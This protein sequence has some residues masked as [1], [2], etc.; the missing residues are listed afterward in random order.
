MNE[1]KFMQLIRD[2]NAMQNDAFRADA[3]ILKLQTENKMLKT[4]NDTL[5]KRIAEL[6][7]LFICRPQ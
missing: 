6:E 3:T 4:E 5:Q 7:A 1:D 2:L